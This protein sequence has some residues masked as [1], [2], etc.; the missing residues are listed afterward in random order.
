M[1]HTPF[2]ARRL[3][4]GSLAVLASGC[5]STGD[6]Y[7][8]DG[9]GYPT[10]PRTAEPVIIH[11]PGVQPV[12]PAYPAPDWRHSDRERE[13]WERDRR[14]RER[15]EREQRDRERWARDRDREQREREA[16][17]RERHERDARERDRE[18]REREARERERREREARERDRRDRERPVR[19]H[20]GRCDYDRY[21]P[22]TG[23]CMPS[24]ERM[25]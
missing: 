5:V 16:R 2:L 17:E 13:R 6:P 8:S 15:W 24:S 12:Y 22:S 20:P 21:N 25:P 19:P 18:R 10:Y 11:S 14:E 1:N 7:Y 4:L 23:Q 9:P 3:A